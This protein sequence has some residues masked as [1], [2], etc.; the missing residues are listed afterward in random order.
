MESAELSSGKQIKYIS[1]SVLY[2]ETI[3]VLR[4]L[5]NREYPQSLNYDSLEKMNNYLNGLKGLS[6]HL[7]YDKSHNIIGW[8]F[9]FSRDDEKWFGII[10]DSKWHGKGLGSWLLEKIKAESNMLNGWVIDHHNF[11]KSNGALYL[12]PLSFY[13]KNGFSVLS[14]ER[15][16]TDTISAVKIRWVES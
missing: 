8:C 12:S 5:W 9:S 11:V 4:H 16:E 13:Q 7:V 3:E 10:V 2:G 1:K 6:H 15:L 14:N